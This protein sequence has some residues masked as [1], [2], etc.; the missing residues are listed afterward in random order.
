MMVQQSV[1]TVKEA[2]NPVTIRDL[3]RMTAGIGDGDDYAEMGMQFYME[4]DGA[5]PGVELPKY[6]ART[7]LLF[8]PGTQFKY[9]I[10][11]EVLAA[12]IT[13]LTGQSFSAYLKEHI[14]EPLGMENTAFRLSECRSQSLATQYSLLKNGELECKG[15]A[16][17]LIPPI[18]KESASGGLISSVDDYMKFQEAL[19]RENVL[20]SKSTT[21]LMWLD[22]LD[23][24]R[25]RN[26]IYSAL[27]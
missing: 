17:C 19:C 26:L 20:L 7:N 22:Q 27:K 10:C 3:F 13:K 24:N 4:T 16:N 9:G 5:C 8:E 1:G 2:E 21:D 25:I 14:F 11:H 15:K 6:L 23:G 18:L 12:L